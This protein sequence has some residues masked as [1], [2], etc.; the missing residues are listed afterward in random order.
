MISCF[1]LFYPIPFLDIESLKIQ[2]EE[3]EEEEEEALILLSGSENNSINN[4]EFQMHTAM[5]FKSQAKVNEQGLG[6]KAYPNLI[7]QYNIFKV[8]I[9]FVTKKRSTFLNH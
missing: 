1:P 9:C 2:E 6:E 4:I 7:T 5:I 8:M 3:E